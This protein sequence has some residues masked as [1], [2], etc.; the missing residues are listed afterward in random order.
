MTKL[1]QGEAVKPVRAIIRPREKIVEWQ[2]NCYVSVT[3]YL[4]RKDNNMPN[5]HQSP[6]TFA[7]RMAAE[8]AFRG[9]P[10][11]PKWPQR[12]KAVY[13]A[14]LIQTRGRN[15]VEDSALECAVS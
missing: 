14:I 12:A 11:D 5:I 4:N 9:L 10:V 2:A 8:A 3:D 6:L 15:I 13:Y 7:E 1:C